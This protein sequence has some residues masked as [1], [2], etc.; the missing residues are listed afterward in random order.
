M[1]ARS[2]EEMRGLWEE[3]H[4]AADSKLPTPEVTPTSHG[5]SADEYH[6]MWVPCGRMGWRGVCL[7]ICWLRQR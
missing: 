5:R 3:W 6:Q 4:A 2:L 7:V 1:T